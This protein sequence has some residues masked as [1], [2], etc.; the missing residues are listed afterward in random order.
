M[1]EETGRPAP[2]FPPW[3]R[4]RVPAGGPIE[5]VR[6]MLRDLRLAT[7][8]QSAR[9]PYL[10]ECFARRTA[11]FMILGSV[12]TRACRF[13]AVGRGA[14]P[15]PDPDEPDRLA[16]AAARLSL[17][18][19]VVTSVTR[20]D[21]PDGGAAQFARTIEALRRR[22]PRCRVEVLTPDFQGRRESVAR[23]VEAGPD[24]FNHNVETAPRL[25]AQVRPQAVYARSLAVLEMAKALRPALTTKSGIM[26]GLG[27]TREETVQTLRDLRGVRCDLVTIGQYLAPTREHAPIVEFVTPETFAW[28]EEQARALGFTGVAAGPFVR[29]SYHAGE[30]YGGRRTT[31]DRRR[32]TDD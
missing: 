20:D 2:R 21:L 22:L 3:L 16:E 15:P 28:Y 27:E 7:V 31:D 32:T 9:C 19:V 4:K 5:E 17:G 30:M 13:C 11:T 29:S 8:C 6:G 25:Y 10:C 18:H 23:V 24:V 1:S 14:P 12:C 26:V